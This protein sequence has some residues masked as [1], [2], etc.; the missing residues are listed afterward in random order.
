[1]CI[2][3]AHLGA[4][5]L[6]K[7]HTAETSDMRRLHAISLEMLDVGKQLATNNTVASSAHKHTI[8]SCACR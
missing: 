7:Q 6:R 4:A 8:I 1:M 5:V 2:L 3:D